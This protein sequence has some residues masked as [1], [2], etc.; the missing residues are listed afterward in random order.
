M[1]LQLPEKLLCVRASLGA[2]PSFNVSLNLVP[3]LAELRKTLQKPVVLLVSPFTLVIVPFQLLL[4]GSVRWTLIRL[5]C[6][7]STRRLALVL[8]TRD[9]GIKPVFFFLPLEE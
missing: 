2:R 3:I 6:K 5:D 8:C 4:R 9:R 7:G 1:L